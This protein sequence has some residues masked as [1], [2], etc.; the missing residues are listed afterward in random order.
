MIQVMSGIVRGIYE[1]LPGELSLSFRP[2][3]TRPFCTSHSRHR[4]AGDAYR[5]CL[6]TFVD[7]V[8]EEYHACHLQNL[9]FRSFKVLF[10]T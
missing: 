7:G 5:S 6:V 2:N 10:I 8:N 1:G 3:K 4:L 9:S